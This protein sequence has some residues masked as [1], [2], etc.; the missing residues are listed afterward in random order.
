MD[1]ILAEY[2]QYADPKARPLDEK[3]IASFDPA[4]LKHLAESVGAASW[5]VPAPKLVGVPEAERSP[6]AKRL[7]HTSMSEVTMPDIM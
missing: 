1:Q 2:H 4:K 7:V 5:K 3:F 6:A